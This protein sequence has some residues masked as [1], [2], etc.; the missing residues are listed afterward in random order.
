MHPLQFVVDAS[1]VVT[2]KIFRICLLLPTVIVKKHAQLLH[3]YLSSDFP[4]MNGPVAM[5][6]LHFVGNAFP[7]DPLK[8][9]RICLSLAAVI[10]K[11]MFSSE[12]NVFVQCFVYNK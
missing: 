6:L 3:L 5:E 9:F 2:L 1:P 10:A 12:S 8:I 11:I 4:T 7:V